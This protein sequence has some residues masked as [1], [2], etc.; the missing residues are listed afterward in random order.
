[1]VISLIFVNFF[2]PIDLYD[3]YALD[4]TEFTGEFI[5]FIFIML[6]FVPYKNIEFTIDFFKLLLTKDDE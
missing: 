1:M 3:E 6:C 5:K 4:K 2:I